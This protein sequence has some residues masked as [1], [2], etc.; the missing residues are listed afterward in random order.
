ME[1]NLLDDFIGDFQLNRKSGVSVVTAEHLSHL[2]S[3]GFS[4]E[5]LFNH[6]CKH[7]L[8]LLHGSRSDISDDHLRPDEL[9][10]IYCSDLA[11]IALLKAIVS[12]RGL[13][14][15]GLQYPFFI[16]KTHP[17]EVRIHG[18]NDETLGNAG[19]VYVLNRREGFVNDPI[20]SWQYVKRGEEAPFAAKFEVVRTD[21]P[22]FL[23][24]LFDAT[25]NRRIQVGSSTT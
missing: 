15:P 18:M 13:P 22:D 11:A 3:V 17:L 7:H 9:G 23:Y 2:K 20:G 21:F 5:D 10:R 24:P 12:N 19:F 8:S 16:D 14:Y 1:K 25:H 6:L 4:V